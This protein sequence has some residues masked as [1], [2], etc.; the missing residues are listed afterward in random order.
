MCLRPSDIAVSS[1]AHTRRFSLLVSKVGPIHFERILYSMHL[2]RRALL[3][4]ELEAIFAQAPNAP[5]ALANRRVVEA[6]NQATGQASSSNTAETPKNRRMP[7]ADDDCP[8]CYESMHDVDV[9]T[10]TFCKE[11]G[12]ALHNEC[13]RQ[14]AWSLPLPLQPRP[15]SGL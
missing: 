15:D 2:P 8:V 5:N 12:N 7:G 11:C 1:P 10:L 4:S 3:T 13:F 14:C 9:K 6:F